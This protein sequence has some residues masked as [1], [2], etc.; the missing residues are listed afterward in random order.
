MAA[1]GY[2]FGGVTL[3]DNTGLQ[4]L[5]YHELT[6]VLWQAVRELKAKIEAVSLA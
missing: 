4:A 3:D 5:A 1:A 2:D 6:A